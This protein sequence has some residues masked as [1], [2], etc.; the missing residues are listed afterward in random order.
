MFFCLLADHAVL[1]CSVAL[2]WNRFYSKTMF[3]VCSAFLRTV[4]FCHNWS[5]WVVIIMGDFGDDVGNSNL[6]QLLE[7]S[8]ACGLAT[9]KE[10]AVGSCSRYVRFTGIKAVC[11]FISSYALVCFRGFFCQFVLLGS[12]CCG[13]MWMFPENATVFSL[14]LFGVWIRI[15]IRRIC[16]CVSVWLVCGWFVNVAVVFGLALLTFWILCTRVIVL[17]RIC[18]TGRYP[19]SV[20]TR[21][22]LYIDDE[23]EDNYPSPSRG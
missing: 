5:L 8:K 21:P 12:K 3:R 18:S 17:F 1:L 19:L 23:F 20:D 9:E 7:S 4:S 22:V 11:V 14:L 13:C 2:V 10:E 15:R 16:W 6:S